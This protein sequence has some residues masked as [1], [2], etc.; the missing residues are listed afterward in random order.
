VTA[1]ALKGVLSA[2]LYAQRRLVVASWAGALIVGLVAPAGAVGAVLFCTLLGV[3][4][5]LAQT[6]G[7]HPHLD[8]CEQGAPLFGRELARAKA[9]VP[10]AAVAVAVLLY[11]VGQIVR[12]A[13]DAALTFAV[14]LA[15]VVTATLI[16]LSATVRRGAARA[17]YVVLAAA[18]SAGAYGLAVAAHSVLGEL[19]FCVVVAFLAVRQYGETLARYDPI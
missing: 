12:G 16:A 10:C 1:R 18:A 7:L 3:S 14:A 4:L 11:T 17:L 19:A 9:L 13:P 8:R 2:R 6:P 5:A 15:A